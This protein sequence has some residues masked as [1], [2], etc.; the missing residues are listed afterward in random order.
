[1]NHDYHGSQKPSFSIIIFEKQVVEM[2]FQMFLKMICKIARDHSV[3]VFKA[4]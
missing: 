2:L 4:Q 1:M 3:D